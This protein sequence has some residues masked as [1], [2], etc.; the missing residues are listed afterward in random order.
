MDLDKY[1]IVA[2]KDFY[3]NSTRK[4]FICKEGEPYAYILPIGEEDLELI[5]LSDE[6]VTSS[7]AFAK[8]LKALGV[9]V[10]LKVTQ[11]F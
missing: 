4:A 1:D 5:P 10:S 9:K 8:E 3:P 6:V 7:L 2:P 11:P